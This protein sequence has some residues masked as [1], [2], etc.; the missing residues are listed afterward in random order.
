MKEVK[1]VVLWLLFVVLVC[2]IGIIAAN[3]SY[4]SLQ[5]RIST[6]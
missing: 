4:G 5:L 3:T 1:Y 2:S 6:N